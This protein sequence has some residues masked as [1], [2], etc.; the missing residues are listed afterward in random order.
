MSWHQYV[1]TLIVSAPRRINEFTEDDRLERV[2]LGN[3][4]KDYHEI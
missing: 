2:R 4:E 3:Q 1:N